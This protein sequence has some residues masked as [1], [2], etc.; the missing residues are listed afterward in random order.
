MIL[1]TNRIWSLSQR[2]LNE[3]AVA[4]DQPLHG[5]FLWFG[6]STSLRRRPVARCAH[7]SARGALAPDSVV[8]QARSDGL[9]AARRPLVSLGTED[10]E[11]HS[12]SNIVLKHRTDERS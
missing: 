8:N 10:Q 5:A 2:F 9:L 11:L 7:F 6:Y 4:A 1:H 12:Y 3:S